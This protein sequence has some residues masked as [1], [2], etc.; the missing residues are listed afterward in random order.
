MDAAKSMH[1][2]HFQLL[3]MCM[4]LL[5][6]IIPLSRPALNQKSTATC[7]AALGLSK[8]HML[9]AL[10][11]LCYSY[12]SARCCA[13]RWCKQGCSLKNLYQG[14]IELLHEYTLLEHSM[15]FYGIVQITDN[16]K[17]I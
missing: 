13:C 11:L 16:L 4:H 15:F 6:C 1:A 17:A 8:L 2:V 7:A 14:K 3:H 9:Q 12:T 10:L 5:R